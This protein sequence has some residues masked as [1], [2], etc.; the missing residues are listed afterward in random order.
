MIDK[1]YNKLGIYF[2]DEAVTIKPLSTWLAINFFTG[3]GLSSFVYLA[4]K[5]IF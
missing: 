5:V 2:T 3:F 1:F 4:S